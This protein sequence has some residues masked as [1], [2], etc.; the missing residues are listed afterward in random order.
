MNI[1]KLLSG[2]A[3]MG[4]MMVTPVLADE[5]K[6]MSQTEARE[7]TTKIPHATVRALTDDEIAKVI[8]RKGP[9]PHATTDGP[10]EMDLVFTDEVAGINVYENGCYVDRLGPTT[11]DGIFKLLDISGA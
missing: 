7:A 2:I 6:V 11:K 8:D 9:P 3:L 1:K 5:C 10:F 4:L